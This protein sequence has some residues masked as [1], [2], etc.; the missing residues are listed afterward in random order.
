MAMT[1]R[2]DSAIFD[3]MAHYRDTR[4]AERESCTSCDFEMLLL[5]SD[6]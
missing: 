5:G 3:L 1:A 2:V 6:C 4:A